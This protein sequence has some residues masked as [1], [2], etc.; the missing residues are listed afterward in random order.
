MPAQQL[1]LLPTTTPSSRPAELHASTA[2]R[3][4]PPQITQI[5]IQ[6]ALDWKSKGCVRTRTGRALFASPRT[7]RTHILLSYFCFALLARAGLDPGKVMEAIGAYPAGVI[8]VEELYKIEC[9]SLPGSGTCSAS[10]PVTPWSFVRVRWSCYCVQ[11][12]SSFPLQNEAD[13]RRLPCFLG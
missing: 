12:V 10:Q 4:A 3:M 5:T 2:F 6:L 11:I 1:P 13:S 9:H 8:D 7:R